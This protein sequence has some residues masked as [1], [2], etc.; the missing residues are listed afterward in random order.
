MIDTTIHYGHV[1]RACS[2]CGQLILG[3]TPETK[4]YG[5][6]AIGFTRDEEQQKIRCF[7]CSLDVLAG[8]PISRKHRM[9][10]K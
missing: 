4:S 9:Q 10:W 1:N 5:D 8:E 2:E 3:L 7:Q 6:E